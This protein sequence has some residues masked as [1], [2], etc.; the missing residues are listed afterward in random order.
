[1]YRTDTTTGGT[2]CIPDCCE[3]VD[4][5]VSI[6]SLAALG[7]AHS[8]AIL[9][10]SAKGDTLSA[11]LGWDHLQLARLTAKWWESGPTR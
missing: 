3:T 2:V 1:M 4:L 11:P 6:T 5:P 10:I 9:I 8:A 7:D